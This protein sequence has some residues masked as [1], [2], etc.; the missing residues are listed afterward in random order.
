LI[1]L[2]GLVAIQFSSFT[3]AKPID[4][5]AEVSTQLDR[6]ELNERQVGEFVGPAIIIGGIATGIGSAT[7]VVVDAI[8]KSIRNSHK[9]PYCQGTG[10][11][12]SNQQISVTAIGVCAGKTTTYPN[13]FDFSQLD[14]KPQVVSPVSYTDTKTGRVTSLTNEAG[15]A[16]SLT[17]TANFPSKA[18]HATTQD[19][20]TAFTWILGTGPHDACQGE[21][22]DTR[23]GGYKFDD[24]SIYSVDPTCISPDCG[25]H[26]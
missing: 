12:S 6:A 20:L 26:T 17:F 21:H 18:T 9:N 25:S 10:S 22:Q 1:G 7:Y 4:G 3:Y 8:Q 16:Q 23:G 2:G 14:G 19:C 24:G 5:A 15:M 13:A 11:W